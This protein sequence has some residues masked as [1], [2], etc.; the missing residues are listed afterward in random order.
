MLYDIMFA[1]FLTSYA[2]SENLL[3][4]DCFCFSNPV[5]N[6]KY[7]E[8]FKCTQVLFPSYC[9]YCDEE[10]VCLAQGSTLQKPVNQL[11]EPL[12]QYT[13]S[14]LRYGKMKSWSKILVLSCLP[15][16][17][18]ALSPCLQ[19]STVSKFTYPCLTCSP[20]LESWFVFG[21]RFSHRSWYDC[22]QQLPIPCLQMFPAGKTKQWMC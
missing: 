13:L 3:C 1:C 17:I 4:R 16:E 11:A 15:R 2:L 21:G 19:L 6:P 10:H 5:K 14:A 7:Y 22:C 9:L 12:K 18:C 20:K 8:A